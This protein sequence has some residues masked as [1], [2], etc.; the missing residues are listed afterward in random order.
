MSSSVG[1]PIGRVLLVPGFSRCTR[2]TAGARYPPDL[3]RSS[4]PDRFASSSASYCAARRALLRR[5]VSSPALSVARWVHSST[6]GHVSSRP[7]SVRR[8]FPR[9][10]HQA[11]V[12]S[13]RSLP[14]A[15]PKLRPTPPCSTE[16]RDSRLR[17]RLSP[18]WISAPMCG[19]RLQRRHLSPEVLAQGGLC[20]PTPHRLATSSVESSASL[21]GLAG[22]RRGLWHSRVILPAAQTFRTLR[23]TFQDC[24]LQL[25]PGALI[26]APQFFRTGTG[27]QVGV[28]DPWHLRGVRKSAS[29]GCGFRRLVR[30][31][32]L[33][34]SWLLA[35]L[36]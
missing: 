5:R 25:P 7:P 13:V 16:T 26:R 30:S 2:R 20:C 17:R 36:G 31:L 3:N 1:M 32:S 10:G 35:S 14:R 27:H 21:P 24:R 22:Y 11:P 6:L 29:C 4:N 15:S 12:S 33:R 8:V 9:Y 19:P 23:C 28:T 34:P 18:Y